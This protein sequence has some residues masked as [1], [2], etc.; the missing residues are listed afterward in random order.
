MNCS[1]F[2]DYGI[3]IHPRSCCPA[4]F[5]MATRCQVHPG[6]F[7][8]LKSLV[9]W[10]AGMFAVLHRLILYYSLLLVSVHLL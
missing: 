10:S 1:D 4:L 8:H 2:I 6:G 3:L 7:H 5:A 9:H